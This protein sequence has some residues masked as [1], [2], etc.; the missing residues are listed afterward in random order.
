LLSTEVSFS[1]NPEFSDFLLF[2]KAYDDIDTC[3]AP[4]RN[5]VVEPVASARAADDGQT[6]SYW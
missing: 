6:T 4:S 1:T 3:G 5:F 2:K